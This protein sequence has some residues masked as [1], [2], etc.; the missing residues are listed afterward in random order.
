MPFWQ[1]FC[2]NW[3]RS[4][5]LGWSVHITKFSCRLRDLQP[6]FSYEHIK[7]KKWRSEISETE[8]GLYEEALSTAVL[9]EDT[10]LI[11]QILKIEHNR[12]AEVCWNIIN[13]PLHLQEEDSYLLD[14]LEDHDLP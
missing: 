5:H 13:S 7:G 9:I 6:G 8:P 10:E 3:F 12:I 14:K 4:G 2:Q 11:K 1:L